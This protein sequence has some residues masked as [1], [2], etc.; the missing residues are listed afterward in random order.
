MWTITQMKGIIMNNQYNI[1]R[2]SNGGTWLQGEF[3]A[4][5]Q[6]L[7]DALGEPHNTNID[8]KVDA[9]WV[10]KLSSKDEVLDGVKFTIYNW[11][12]G[13]A[14]WEDG[15]AVETITNWHIGGTSHRAVTACLEVLSE[16]NVLVANTSY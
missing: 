9:E 7:V 2:T 16:R 1:E 3:D 11:K 4:S 6:S 15:T 5:Y 13:D 14:F 8:G 10:F 12:N